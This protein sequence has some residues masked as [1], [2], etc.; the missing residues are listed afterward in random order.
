LP[1]NTIEK[2]QEAEV[3]VR[4]GVERGVVLRELGY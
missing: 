2:L 4:L 1:E 3:K